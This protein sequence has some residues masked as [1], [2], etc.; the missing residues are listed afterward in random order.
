MEIIAEETENFK[1]SE[2]INQ[3]FE[4]YF[5][6]IE[7]CYDLINNRKAYSDEEFFYKL[8][9]FAYVVD[10]NDEDRIKIL[11]LYYKKKFTNECKIYTTMHEIRYKERCTKKGCDC[12]Q[13]NDGIDL[14]ILYT[15]DVEIDIKH[16]YT[17][18]EIKKMVEEKRIVILYEI[19]RPYLFYDG[20]YLSVP[21]NPKLNREDYYKFEYVCDVGEKGYWNNY[22]DSYEKAFMNPKSRFYP[23][24]LKYIRTCA[25]K[26]KLISLYK[27]SLN[28]AKEALEDI[29]YDDIFDI[30]EPEITRKLM[31][32]NGLIPNNNSK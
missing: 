31:L 16:V 23:Y 2:N 18:D 15:K 30:N 7:N 20:K 5:K 26:R 28:N 27:N 21:S 25:D 13:E 14:K 24:T 3:E 32:L 8:S 1:W 11:N 4:K 22:H 17:V 9:S 29:R 10:W 6:G 19:E 12:W